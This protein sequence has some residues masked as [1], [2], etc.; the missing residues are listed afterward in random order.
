MQMALRHSRQL[1][2]GH[3]ESYDYLISA[4]GKIM[5]IKTIFMICL[6]MLFTAMG[7]WSENG[8]AQSISP[9]SVY[10]LLASK[11]DIILIDVRTQLLLS[12]GHRNI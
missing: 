11:Q 8:E 2:R 1:P 3:F 4:K 7:S 10:E 9:E 12:L 5:K 6:F